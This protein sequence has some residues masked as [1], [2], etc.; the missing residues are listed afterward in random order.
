MGSSCR[1]KSWLAGAGCLVAS[2]CLVTL[3]KKYAQSLKANKY[4]FEGLVSFFA[5]L[6]RPLKP[7]T[8]D[9]SCPLLLEHSL[10]WEGTINKYFIT[11]RQPKHSKHIP[12]LGAQG[13]EV[14]PPTRKII[15]VVTMAACPSHLTNC[16]TPLCL[17]TGVGLPF[18]HTTLFT[19]PYHT[20][21]IPEKQVT[22]FALVFVA[23]RLLLALWDLGRG[24][25][26]MHILD[27]TMP[28]KL[29]LTLPY[30]ANQASA[31]MPCNN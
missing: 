2:L 25:N 1:G 8:W 5:F 14:L 12:I 24:N 17:G 3:T 11:T 21:S 27:H 20:H 28:T 7:V 10:I 29:L 4:S 9:M 15:P 23:P 31:A 30:Y 16:F 26:R 13:L 19:V 6:V 18:L 22:I